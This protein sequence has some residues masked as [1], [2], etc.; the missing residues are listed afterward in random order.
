MYIKVKVTPGVKK[1]L[2]KKEAPDTFVVAVREEAKRGMANKR[3]REILQEHFP[4]RKVRLVT[5]HASA[6][7]IFEVE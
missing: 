1:E 2:V 3:V 5:G 6:H 7:K 4:R